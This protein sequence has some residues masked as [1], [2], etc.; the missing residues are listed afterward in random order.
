MLNRRLLVYTSVRISYP[1]TLLEFDI[2]EPGGSGLTGAKIT[3][4]YNGK[5]VTKTTDN[6]GLAVFY[7]VP[8]NL[9]IR[10]TVTASGYEDY[11]GSV[12]LAPDEYGWVNIEMSKR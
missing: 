4:S 8:T 9:E 10:Y 1:P 7:D 11:T 5:T 6:K 12:N 3:L 2:D